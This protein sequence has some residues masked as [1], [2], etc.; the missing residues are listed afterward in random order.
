M[1][2]VRTAI[3]LAG[4]TALFMGVGYLIGGQS[5]ALIALLVAAGMNLFTY[6]NADKLVLSM[7]GA[8]EVD[9]R[10]APDLVRLVRELAQRAGLPMPRV[11]LMDN[12]QPNA[13]ATGRDPQH[14]AVAA[15]TGLLQMLS[16]DEIAGVIAH[17]L[18]HVRNRDTLTMT[19]TATIAGAI[20]MLAQFGLF[21]GGHRDD[22]HG[23]GLIGTIAMVILAPIA[24]MLVQMAISRTREYAADELGARISGRPDALASAL[25][26]ISGAAQQIENPTAERSPATAHLFIVNPL[27]GH[28]MDNL[29]ATHPSTENRIAAL[30]QV[31]RAMGLGG[32]GRPRAAAPASPSEPS[33][34]WGNAG[35]R[36]GGP[37]G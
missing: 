21:F 24:A 23:A 6:W 36:R 7:H 28:G 16:R 11:Y 2:Y 8:H 33:G 22:N 34:P 25:V 26:K 12:P 13:F 17:E 31:A 14:A 3:L 10:T 5:G 18:A 9:E 29:F 15:T 4:L 30:D 35:A 20:S 19:I 1:N 32:L 27:T 37:W